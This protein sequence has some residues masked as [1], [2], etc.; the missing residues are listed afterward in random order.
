[1]RVVSILL[2]VRDDKA[3]AG[4]W[5]VRKAIETSTTEGLGK[6]ESWV[7]LTYKQLRN[8]QLHNFA[9]DLSARYWAKSNIK[10]V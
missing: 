6:L 4:Y 1:M 5:K 7:C 10:G 8:N 9:T 3:I 2:P